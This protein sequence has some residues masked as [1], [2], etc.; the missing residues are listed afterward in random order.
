M[1]AV[2]KEYIR[3]FF[4]VGIKQFRS[5]VTVDAEDNNILRRRNIKE[6]VMFIN[7]IRYIQNSLMF[8]IY[9]EENIDNTL[10]T[11]SIPSYNQSV[12]FNKK[13]LTKIM[14]IKRNYFLLPGNSKKKKKQEGSLFYCLKNFFP[15]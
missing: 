13:K 15:P 4:E 5:E 10:R 9:S 7:D 2:R 8:N 6:I 3:L 14:D 1:E 11:K 12:G